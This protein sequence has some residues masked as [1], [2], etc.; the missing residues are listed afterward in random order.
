LL[1]RRNLLERLTNVAL[2][3]QVYFQVQAKWQSMQLASLTLEK[4]WSNASFLPLLTPISESIVRLLSFFLHGPGRHQPTLTSSIFV[5]LLENLAALK[6]QDISN[7]AW[8]LAVLGM[9]HDPFMEAAKQQLIDRANQY[10]ISGYNVMTYFKGQELANLLWAFAIVNFPFDALETVVLPYMLKT[11]VGSMK[12]LNAAGIAKVYK[13]Q[14]LA[15]IAWS[16]AIFDDYPPNLTKYLYSGLV[17][18]G[19]NSHMQNLKK[20][21]NDGGLQRQAIMSLIYLQL[22]LELEGETNGLFLPELFPEG[23]GRQTRSSDDDMLDMGFDLKLST[24]KIQRDVSAA[25]ERIGFHHVEEHVI[26]LEDL[27][28]NAGVGLAETT[29]EVIAID[30][31]N[32]EERIAIEVDG[33]AHYVANIETVPAEGGYPKVNNGRLE[34]SFHMNGDRHGLNGPTVLKSR[35]LERMGWKAIN[36]PFW[37]WYDMGGDPALE[38]E[39]CRRILG[40][41]LPDVWK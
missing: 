25:F 37:E 6:P 31:A 7:T 39:Y 24:S 26:P 15:N 11:T 27:L 2:Y 16:C 34:Y 28:E 18:V 19:E 21:Y 36:I 5:V 40:E 13:R 22:A 29:M 38:E 8:A 23:W 12:S 20:C 14:E 9:R 1:D 35:L 32:V 30:I 33:P 41:L 3:R 17:G 10:L 4:Y